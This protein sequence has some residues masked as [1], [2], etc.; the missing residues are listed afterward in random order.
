MGG[1]SVPKFYPQVR[2]A[3]CRRVGSE[4]PRSTAGGRLGEARD[5][6]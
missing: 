4:G 6:V 5:V 3:E 2:F 1:A